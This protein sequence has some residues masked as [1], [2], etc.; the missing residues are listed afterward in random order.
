[1]SLIVAGVLGAVSLAGSIAGKAKEAKERRRSQRFVEEQARLAKDWYTR[2][3]SRNYLD[4]AE[5]SS[6]QKVLRDML[7]EN[8]NRVDNSLVKTGGTAESAI[9]QKEAAGK[10]LADGTRQMAAMGTQRKMTLHQI[11]QG[12]KDKY[13]GMKIANMNAKGDAWSTF[14]ENSGTVMN[15][16]IKAGG[17]SSEGG[18]SD[19][20]KKKK[21]EGQ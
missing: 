20:F 15:S 10:T 5:G 17:A 6:Q 3:S 16:A 1:M 19:L 7:R 12:Q 8:T 9:A 21:E 4:T 11:Y 18:W 14:A 13:D 2:E